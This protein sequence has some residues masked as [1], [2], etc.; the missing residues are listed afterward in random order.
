VVDIT[1][2]QA[3]T[4]AHDGELVRIR[5]RLVDR[6]DTGAE[7]LLVLQDGAHVFNA[8][9]DTTVTDDW[10]QVA[11]HRQGSV[12]DV[13]GVCMVR[14]DG[15]SSQRAPVGFKVLMQSPAD[16]SLV[17]AAPWWTPTELLAAVGVLAAVVLGAFVWVAVL[18]SRV[19]Q[20]TESLRDAKDAAETANQAKSEFL[21]NM[22]HEIR[23]PM[24]GVL[25]MVELV[26]DTELQPDQRNYLKKAK[27]SAEALLR[28]INDILDYS[29]VE[30]GRLELEE[31][32]F[33][34]RE[35]LARRFTRSAPAPIAR[36]SSSAA[37]GSRRR[38]RRWSAIACGSARSD[39]PCGQRHQVHRG[40]ARSSCAP[41]AQ[42]AATASCS[43]SRSPTPARDSAQPSRR[44]SSR[45]SARPTLRPPAGSAAPVS[46]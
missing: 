43:T 10:G 31:A 15:D 39:E 3:L 4:G 44:S 33:D 24:N 40:P 18:R 41:A 36:S 25:G 26:L 12:I 34:I 20:Q 5:G 19:R 29:K 45:R 7:H 27:G 6:I 37:R 38:R 8:G 22:S 14:T 9:W 35:A 1:A 23:T 13:V 46:A 32:P 16:V 28:V 42:T 30:A 17:Q 2:E 11:S 21:A